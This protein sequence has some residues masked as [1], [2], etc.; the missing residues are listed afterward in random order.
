MGHTDWQNATWL[1]D[2][3]GPGQF[4]FEF[5]VGGGSVEWA[6]AYVASPGCAAVEI[7]GQSPKVNFRGICPWVVSG[8]GVH[9]RTRYQTHDITAAVVPGK[10]NAIGI[11]AGNVMVSYANVVAVIMVQ[12]VGQAPI[13]FTTSTPGWQQRAS[14]Y[15]TLGNAWQTDIDW[16]QEEPGWSSAGFQPKDSSWHPATVTV[17]GIQLIIASQIKFRRFFS[18]C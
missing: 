5:D 14:S 6:R 7:N 9:P 1:A 18:L 3:H 11:L 16:T 15:V 12:L 2:P 10:K 13:F 8:A 17:P 4:R